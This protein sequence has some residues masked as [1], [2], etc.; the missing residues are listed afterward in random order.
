MKVGPRETLSAAELRE[1]FRDWVTQ[2]G[3]EQD[4]YDFFLSYRW[5]P[6][7]EDL[8]LRLYSELG[9][10]VVRANEAPRTF[11]DKMRLEPG[12][13]FARDFAASLCRTRIAVV[14]LSAAALERMTASDESSPNLE[15]E[16][17]T[18]P[19]PGGANTAAM[20]SCV[21]PLNQVSRAFA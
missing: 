13:N 6:L 17:S 16:V 12:G 3:L 7:D 14:L 8:T 5:T 15:R 21:C 19:G 10:Q 20:W 1:R 9:A 2:R 11:L 4:G 18:L